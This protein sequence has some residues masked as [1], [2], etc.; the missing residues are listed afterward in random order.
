[1][2]LPYTYEDKIES[3]LPNKL[4]GK[5]SILKEIAVDMTEDLKVIFVREGCKCWFVLDNDKKVAKT[6]A[7]FYNDD[8]QLDSRWGS[9][10]TKMYVEFHL[11]NCVT[12]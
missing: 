9:F 8:F 12:S 6:F 10:V 3:Y 7:M 11:S 4:P 1:M 2:F 5:H